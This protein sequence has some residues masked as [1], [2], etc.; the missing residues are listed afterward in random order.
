MLVILTVLLTVCLEIYP[1]NAPR[2]TGNSHLITSNDF[3]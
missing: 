2:N 3:L 1:D